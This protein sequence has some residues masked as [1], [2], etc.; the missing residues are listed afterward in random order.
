MNDRSRI[1][2]TELDGV[3]LS[4]D[5]SRLVLSLRNSAGQ[6]ISLSLP[7][8]SLNTVLT[9]MPRSAAMGTRH[10][11]DAWSMAPANG[12]DMILTLRTPEG[13]QCRS[14]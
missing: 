2:A 10:S 3:R 7:V 14:R 11:L 8:T 5:G 12:H 4:P 6:K 9:A 13:L 1:D